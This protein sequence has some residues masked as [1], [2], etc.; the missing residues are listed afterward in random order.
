MNLE[1]LAELS[2]G[3]GAAIGVLWIVLQM[4][5]ELKKKGNGHLTEDKLKVILAAE[6]KATRHDLRDEIQKAFA[7]VVDE[8]RNLR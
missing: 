1:K 2:I 3:L 6:L 5:R 7:A 8:I 4:I